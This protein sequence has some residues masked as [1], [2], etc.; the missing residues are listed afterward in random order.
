MEGT[1]IGAIPFTELEPG[2]KRIKRFQEFNI[3][4]I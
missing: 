2:I 1:I 3:C 4:L